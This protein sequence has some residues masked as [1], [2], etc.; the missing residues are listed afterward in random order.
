MLE[1]LV[2]GSVVQWAMLSLFILMPIGA[3]FGAMF[4]IGVGALWDHM[5]GVKRCTGK[6]TDHEWV[7]KPDPRKRPGH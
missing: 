3:L 5:H 1:P 4:G 7:A 2:M 6:L